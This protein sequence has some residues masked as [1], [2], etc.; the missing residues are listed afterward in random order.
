MQP[1]SQVGYFHYVW[2]WGIIALLAKDFSILTKRLSRADMKYQY[3]YYWYGK[4]RWCDWPRNSYH[5]ETVFLSAFHTMIEDSP[6]ADAVAK[7]SRLSGRKPYS[8]L[9]INVLPQRTCS[10]NADLLLDNWRINSWV[11]I[12]KN[13]LWFLTRYLRETT[14][15]LR[16][17]F[18]LE[19]KAFCVYP[20][21]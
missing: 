3:Y 6:F 11:N 19:R 20:G 21:L 14:I 7:W 2:A 16:V 4:L 12:L 9:A 13:S 10:E 17:V 15:V 18:C 5:N 8:T 1:I